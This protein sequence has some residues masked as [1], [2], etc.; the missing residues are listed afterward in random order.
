VFE[1]RKPKPLDG[2][3]KVGLIVENADLLET[4]AVLV[5]VDTEGRVVTKQNVT[6]GGDG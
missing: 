2:D 3:G 1:V 6:I 5:V 4:A